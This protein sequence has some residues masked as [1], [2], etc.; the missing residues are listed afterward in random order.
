MDKRIVD[1][2]SS[3]VCPYCDAPVIH[4]EG[5]GGGDWTYDRSE[6]DLTRLQAITEEALDCLRLH[7]QWER[8]TEAQRT[9]LAVRGYKPFD[10]YQTWKAN[11]DPRP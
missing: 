3:E 10:D 8:L 9:E 4:R 6:I 1:G 7:R 5:P 2:A 11:R